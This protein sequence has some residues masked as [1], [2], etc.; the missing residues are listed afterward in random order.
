MFQCTW[1]KK[2]SK[3]NFVHTYYKWSVPRLI[4]GSLLCLSKD[5]FNTAVFATVANREA[6]D[7]VYGLL[8][9]RF[10]NTVD[11]LDYFKDKLL[12]EETWRWGWGTECWKGN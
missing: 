9:V 11:V 6:K 7:L 1:P 10:V 12:A 4:F 5:R 8:E 3:S 2:Q